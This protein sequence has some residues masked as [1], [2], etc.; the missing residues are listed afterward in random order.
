MTAAVH[1]AFLAVAYGLK[2]H[3]R[4]WR[5]DAPVGLPVVCLPG[6]ART[7]EDF[8]PLADALSARGRR[9]LAISARGR[10]LSDRDPDPSRYQLVVESNDV[11]ALLDGLGITRAVFVGTSR[12]GLQ[13]MMIAALR[14]ALPHAVVLNDIGPVIEREGLMRIRDALM[15]ASVPADHVDG[16]ARLRAA[17]GHRF[18]ALTDED[19]SRWSRRAWRDAPDGLEPACDPAL[20]STVASIDF[21]QPLAPLWP[22]FDALAAIPVMIVRGERSDILSEASLGELQ[23]RRPDLEVH[24][25]PGQGHA[26]L[27]DDQPAME[28][29][30]RFL[31]ASD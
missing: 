3:V 10:G 5:P 20:S 21:D 31:E 6:L 15:D 22:L 17:H 7:L 19:W 24:V 28:A 8:V 26:P 9:V 12:G 13:S 1:D 27:L 25:T 30:A 16:A 2:L 14:P 23:A 18:P 29:I 4:E 11:I